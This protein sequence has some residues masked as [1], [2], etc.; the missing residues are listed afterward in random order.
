MEGAPI[1][2][3]DRDA[4][5]ALLLS[6][7]VLAAGLMLVASPAH[8]FAHN[9]VTNPY[10][11]ALPD[12]LTLAVVLSP[13]VTIYTWGPRRKR[14]LL[15][16]I[17]VVQ[18]PVAVIGFVPIPQPMAAPDLFLTALTVTAALIRLARRAARTHHVRRH[19]PG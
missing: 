7:R 6:V 2:V 15:M 16:L 5:F 18:L 1:L 11:H 14:L 4:S 12:L 17:A 8:A 9:R 10:L 3:G 13:I 19:G